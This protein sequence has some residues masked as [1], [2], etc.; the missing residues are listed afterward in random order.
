MRC[1]RFRDTDGMAVSG[2]FRLGQTDR[3][4]MTRNFLHFIPRCG[5]SEPSLDLLGQCQDESVPQCSR[6]CTHA[7]CDSHAREPFQHE[8]KCHSCWRSRNFASKPAIPSAEIQGESFCQGHATRNRAWYAARKPV[9][10]RNGRI[11]S[12]RGPEAGP[13]KLPESRKQPRP[14]GHSLSG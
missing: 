2:M 8:M 13:R 14:R 3:L 11:Q 10:L 4:R 6:L 7:R 9:R 1:D 12:C 5:T